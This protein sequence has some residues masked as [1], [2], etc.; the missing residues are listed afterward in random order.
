[1]THP[2]ALTKQYFKRRVVAA[3]VA[4]PLLTGALLLGACDDNDAGKPYLSFAG[5]GFV[6]NY[7]VGEIYYGFV[8]KIER[9]LPEGSVV[10]ARFEN[11]AGGPPLVVTQSTA[12]G[13][14]D[15]SFR[16]PSLTG[17][18]ANRPYKAE[19][20]VIEP[21]TRKVLARYETTYKSSIDQSALPGR[22]TN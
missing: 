16:S 2:R 21:K 14:I 3:V 1:M 6:F 22:E 4:G 20:L 17:V 9:R 10:E 19:L 8:A 5:G 15:Y 11:P 18:K 12:S 7:R 13:R